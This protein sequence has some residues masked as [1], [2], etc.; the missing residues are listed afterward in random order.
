MPHLPP[1]PQE[2]PQELSEEQ[3]L[4]PACAGLVEDME[5]LLQTVIDLSHLSDA[6]MQEVSGCWAGQC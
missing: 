3:A 6:G 4:S 5:Q 1:L 2:L